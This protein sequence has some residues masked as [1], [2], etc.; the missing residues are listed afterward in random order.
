MVPLV[1]VAGTVKVMVWASTTAKLVAATPLSF[2]AVA[3][4]KSVPVTVTSVPV[5]TAPPTPEVGVKLVM[6]G[7]A[8]TPRTPMVVGVPAL[9][10][11]WVLMS[12]AWAV[13]L[14]TNSP[15][16]AANWASPLPERLVV[17]RKEKC[18]MLLKK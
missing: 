8:A 3:P 17:E 9:A 6:V 11:A 4:V 5:P 12:V 14:P 13:K 2:T 18:C 16:T 10:A 7:T 1:A 15:I